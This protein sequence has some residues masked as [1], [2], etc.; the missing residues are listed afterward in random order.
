MRK[1][2]L[3]RFKEAFSLNEVSYSKK[4]S[5]YLL[6]FLS[7][8]DLSSEYLC[9]ISGKSLRWLEAE[10]VK[11]K[12]APTLIFFHAPLKGTLMS[13]NR[14]AEGDNYI[15]QPHRKIHKIIKENGQIFLW[16]S[17]HTHIAPTNIKFNH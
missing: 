8:D 1:R 5:P 12:G 9:E 14:S 7:V 4:I 17:G 13:K 16:L 2:K 10:L 6:I 3:E 11:D 15:A